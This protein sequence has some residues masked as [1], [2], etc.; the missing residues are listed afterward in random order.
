MKKYFK[1]LWKALLGRKICKDPDYAMCKV[2]DSGEAVYKG[3]LDTF[4]THSAMSGKTYTIYIT[5]GEEGFV[6]RVTTENT[7]K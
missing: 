7:G 6:K 1:T 5:L 3:R 4:V 2:L